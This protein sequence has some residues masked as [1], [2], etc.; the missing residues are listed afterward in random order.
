V[1]PQK[2]NSRWQDTGDDHQCAEAVSH[3]VYGLVVAV[4]ATQKGAPCV[5][6]RDE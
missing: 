2:A 3:V 1:K 4:I 6:I 5:S